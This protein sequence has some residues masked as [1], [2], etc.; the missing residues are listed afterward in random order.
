MQK[1]LIAVC[2]DEL[3]TL[4]MIADSI[5]SVFAKRNL[6]AEIAR[7]PSVESLRRQMESSMFDLMFLDIQMPGLSGITLAGQLRKE[8]YR[9]RIVFVSGREEKVFDALQTRPFGF[10][11]K[12]YFFQD[13]IH[14]V[15]CF[16]QEYKEKDINGMLAVRSKNGIVHIRAAETVYIEGSGK[17]QLLFLENRQEPVTIHSTM[18]SLT[19]ILEPLGFI[20]I[21]KGF[22]VNYQYIAAIRNTYVE[23]SD[24]RELPL[25]RRKSQ[26][27]K[28]KYMEVLK[29]H[30]ALIL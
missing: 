4:D 3:D 26:K 5:A 28:E 30:G 8:N 6:T 22:L 20:R 24:E 16:I 18:D 19:D 23:L 1:L 29:Q 14:V 15:D 13:I 11:R 21:H 17:S 9:T 12:R 2:D 25:S 7:F 27:I 10:V